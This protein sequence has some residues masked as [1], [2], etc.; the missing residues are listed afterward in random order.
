MNCKKLALVI[1]FSLISL[2]G[3]CD[4]KNVV[5]DW[6]KRSILWGDDVVNAIP[7]KEA[8]NL[9]IINCPDH[10]ENVVVYFYQTK[11]NPAVIDSTKKVE[12]YFA[13]PTSVAK[14]YVTTIPA[15]NFLRYFAVRVEITTAEPWPTNESSTT[16]IIPVG[17][18]NDSLDVSDLI[19]VKSTLV[20]DT[21]KKHIPGDVIMDTTI[22]RKTV[23]SKWNNAMVY[24][25]PLKSEISS[26]EAYAA[27]GIVTFAGS[28]VFHEAE[29]NFAAVT[30]VKIRWKPTIDNPNI[31]KYDLY[32][33]SR[34]SFVI[35]AVLND[36]DYK[37]SNIN[38]A[39]IGLK[40]ML[41][42]NFEALNIGLTI[43]TIL[44]EQN[45]DPKLN[46]QTKLVSGLFFGLSFS[47][48]VFSKFKEQVP[49][50]GLSP[51]S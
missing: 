20:V 24:S 28:G 49:A 36:L 3:F 29:G 22:I 42:I 19:T 9:K 43:G 26:F 33:R 23:M 6:N 10:I 14:E 39:A 8:F 48:A 41:G 1:V 30:G 35:G 13:Q 37:G 45:I 50:T 11:G 51:K 47:S 32:F 40:P 38:S 7:C 25:V 16:D 17:T 46:N 34:F 18:P 2:P 15:Q 4:L 44:G 27:G 12:M 5:F 21:P 31:G